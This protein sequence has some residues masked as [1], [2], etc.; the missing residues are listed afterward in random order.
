MLPFAAIFLLIQNPNDISRDE[1][2]TSREDE[3]GVNRSKTG[4]FKGVSIILRLP[5]LVLTM[6]ALVCLNGSLGGFSFYGSKAAKSIF[7]LKSSTADLLF[8]VSTVVTGVLGT[9]LGGILLDLMGSNVKTALLLCIL[10]VGTAAAG[11]AFS[12][13]ATANLATFSPGFLVG[14][15]AMFISS[16]PAVA[17]MLWTS[18][19]NLRPTALAVSEILNHV[20]GDIPLPVLLGM[21]QQHV[22]N[23]RLTMCLCTAILGISAVMFMFARCTVTKELLEQEEEV[24]IVVGGNGDARGDGEGLEE[25]LLPV[26]AE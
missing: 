5:A 26:S 15:T 16:A 9:L 17:V 23:W 21:F 12:F 14:E 11:L 25:S 20:I 3:N 18:P 7:K 2:I 24:V 4:F 8:G 6:L 1:S 22:D 19:A 13:A 10:G